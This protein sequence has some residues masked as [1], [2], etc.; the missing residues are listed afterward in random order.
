MRLVALVES[1]DHVCCRYRLAAFRPYLEAAG[2]TLDLRPWP[3][4]WWSRLRL[5]RALD[6]ADV[7]ILQRRLLP[8]W[9]L[10]LLRC[11]AP[12]LV[13]DFDD[14][15]FVRDSYSPKGPHSASRLHRFMATVETADAVVAGNR[16]LADEATRWAAAPGRVHLVP[17]CVDPSRYA[18]AR[19]DG[20]GVEL[21]WVGSSSTLRGLEIVRPL[22][23]RVGR[24][25]PGARLK[26]VSDRFLRLNHLP[27]IERPWSECAEAADVAS[28]DVGISWV[29]DDL[30]SRGKCG[31]KVLQYMAAG[32]PVV[33][34]PVGVQ[35]ELV[36]PGETGF[37]AC[38]PDEW[39]AAL[40][41]LAGDPDLRR[42]LGAA[43]RRLVEAE[44]GVAA[45]AARWVGLLDGLRRPTSGKGAA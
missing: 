37:L 2:H 24:E 11:A 28:A 27:V 30:W 44:F 4:R 8:V 5:G 41:R 19:H 22:L 13:F 33:A 42:R 17:T 9:L 1:P 15:V 7:V 45:G 23:E 34:N 21:V 25:V 16:Y 39:V 43:G 38:T 32:L 10:Y 14:A 29:P 18:P 20:D 31:L 36:R 3:R 12:R 6:G 40:R 26:L 35:A